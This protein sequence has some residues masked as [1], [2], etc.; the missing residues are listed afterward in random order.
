MAKKIRYS[1]E[2]EIVRFLDKE[3]FQEVTLEELQ[4]EPYKSLVKA[5]DCFSDKAP[6]QQSSR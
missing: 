6:K 4:K 3:G 1:Q 2:E 5:P